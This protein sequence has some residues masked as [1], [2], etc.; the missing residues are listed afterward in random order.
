[1]SLLLL[2]LEH[3]LGCLAFALYYLYSSSVAAIFTTA[4]FTATL[5]YLL[6]LLVWPSANVTPLLPVLAPLSAL[7]PI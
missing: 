6:Y 4:V 7:P 3:P 5:F 2:L 1:L